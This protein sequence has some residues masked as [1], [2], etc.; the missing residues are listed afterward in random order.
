ME[1][2]VIFKI[3]AVGLVTAICGL[4]LKRAGRE[5]IATVVSLVGL[6]VSLVMM[7]DVVVQL[8]DT[9]RSLFGL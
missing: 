7:L 6:A 3:V 4:V 8:Y 1:L 9:L 5:E 2:T